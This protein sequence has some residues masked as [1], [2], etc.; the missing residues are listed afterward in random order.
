MIL[1]SCLVYPFS[2]RMKPSYPANNLRGRICMGQG[3]TFESL[4]NVSSTVNA[5]VIAIAG[6][7]LFWM[8]FFNKT[9][10]KFLKKK[11]SSNFNSDHRYIALPGM[12]SRNIFCCFRRNFINFTDTKRIILD[13]LFALV[14]EWFGYKFIMITETVTNNDLLIYSFIY[15]FLCD[16]YFLIFLP[17]LWIY[18]SWKGNWAG[19][20]NGSRKRMKFIMTGSALILPENC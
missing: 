18:K 7:L 2:M 1:A 20:T 17:F 15:S 5:I 16:L 6:V 12:I 14:L 3:I 9:T 4:T 8:F 10:E 11:S 19:W 13:L